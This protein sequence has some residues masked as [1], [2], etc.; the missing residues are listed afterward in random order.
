MDEVLYL[1]FRQHGELRQLLM[2]TG[3]AE[4]IY[5]EEHDSFLGS[6]T[7]SQGANELGKSLMRVRERLRREGAR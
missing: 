7:I 3:F 1:K 6:G 4:L 5:A 2:S